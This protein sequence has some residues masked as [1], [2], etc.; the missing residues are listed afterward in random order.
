MPQGFGNRFMVAILRSPLHG[1]LGPDFAL[2]EVTGRRTHRTITLPV[3]AYADDGTYW[4]L[5]RRER[6]WWR[7]LRDRPG[8]RFRSHGISRRM[9]SQ[10]IEEP[11]EVA[12]L[13]RD[14]LRRRPTHARYLGIA[15][16]ADGH[17]DETQLESAAR[18]R[19]FIRL[20]PE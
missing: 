12:Q 15:M 17:F 18:E 13:L 9:H 5:S 3:N 7:N 1:V 14:H 11:H 6:T 19:V 16:G 20:L 4:I 10:L 2:I 8:V